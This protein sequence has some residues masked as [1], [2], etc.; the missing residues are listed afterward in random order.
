M[1][2]SI[3]YYNGAEAEIK[4]ERP[5][6]PH[7]PN[8]TASL[9]QEP[10]GTPEAK[11]SNFYDKMPEVICTRGAFGVGT[12]SAKSTYNEA[13]SRRAKRGDSTGAEVQ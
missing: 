6:A 3:I 9:L 2:T 13:I 1:S 5:K 11:A 4:N 10:V 12:D 7:F 8:S